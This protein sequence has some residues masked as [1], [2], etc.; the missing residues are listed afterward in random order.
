[1]INQVLAD[2]GAYS[3]ATGGRGRVAF[4]DGLAFLRDQPLVV[5]PRHAGESAPSVGSGRRLESA[6]LDDVEDRRRFEVHELR[7]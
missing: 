3:V 5:P 1:M 6:L 7:E 2:A 4:P